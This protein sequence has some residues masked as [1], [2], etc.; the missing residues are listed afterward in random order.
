M[1]W[2][3]FRIDSY[4]IFFIEDQRPE[5]GSGRVLELWQTHESNLRRYEIAST[6]LRLVRV[7]VGFNGVVCR[8]A[9]RD[10]NRTALSNTMVANRHR[11]G[12]VLRLIRVLT[13]A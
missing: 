9:L 12:E 13:P 3:S 10:L 4:C 11:N 2:D 1:G 7:W 6:F 8:D 5:T